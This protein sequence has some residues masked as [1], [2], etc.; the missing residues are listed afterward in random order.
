MDISYDDCVKFDKAVIGFSHKYL[1]DF[2]PRDPQV[3]DSLLL[4]TIAAF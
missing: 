4:I 2:C 1:R 3:L